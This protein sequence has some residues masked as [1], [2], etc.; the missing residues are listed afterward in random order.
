MDLK[1]K[2]ALDKKLEKVSDKI[3]KVWFYEFFE[4]FSK[5]EYD[6]DV[7][8]VVEAFFNTEEI[9][10]MNIKPPRFL[11]N[12][13]ASKRAMGQFMRYLD[14]KLDSL[15][16]R[17]V[18]VYFDE[19]LEF[20]EENIDTEISSSTNLI[21]FTTLKFSKDINVKVENQEKFLGDP[22]HNRLYVS[23][24]LGEFTL[25]SMNAHKRMNADTL[26]FDHLKTLTGLE[27]QHLGFMVMQK[28][29]S[30]VRRYAPYLDA[31]GVGLN[32]RNI[33]AQMFYERLGGVFYSMNSMQPIPYYK[34]S[35]YANSSALGIYFDKRKIKELADQ[36]MLLALNLQEFKDRRLEQ[37][38][39]RQRHR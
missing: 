37:E 9:N 32:K 19:M 10:R 23:A 33:K 3:N 30:F 35:E 17:E 6:G 14:E 12:S 8:E 4:L 20:F 2:R 34:L 31:F 15:N 36:H 24:K 1:L 22:E 7:Y 39:A 18:Q 5:Y 25:A 29:F 11:I 28:F 21:K 16:G 38:R 27:R 13:N 26:E